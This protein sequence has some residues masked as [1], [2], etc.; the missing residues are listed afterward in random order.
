MYYD[1]LVKVPVNTGKI[2]LNRRGDT[3][4]VEYTVIRNFS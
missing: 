2:N 1:F 4:Y 3:R